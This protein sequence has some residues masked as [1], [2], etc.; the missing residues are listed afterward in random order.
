MT[1][2]E[3]LND[4]SALEF[5]ARAYYSGDPETEFLFDEDVEWGEAAYTFS[6][7][8]EFDGLVIK[9]VED[10]GGMDMGSTRY[11][12]FSISDCNNTRFFRKDGFY[13]SHYGTD[14]D[15][16]FREVKPVQKTITVYS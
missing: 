1:T 13:A 3:E 8:V 11:V 5:L 12:V 2:L 14:W 7:D 16:E 10:F 15:G 6:K 9:C 4:E